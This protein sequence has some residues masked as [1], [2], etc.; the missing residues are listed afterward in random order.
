MSSGELELMMCVD[1]GRMVVSEAA[2][3]ARAA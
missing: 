1:I 2:A 3:D